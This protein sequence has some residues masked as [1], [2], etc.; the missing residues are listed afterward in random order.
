M[1]KVKK[2]VLPEELLLNET[3]KSCWKKKKRNMAQS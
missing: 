3:E 1:L 2:S